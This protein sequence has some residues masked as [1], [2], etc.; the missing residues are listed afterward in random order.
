MKVWSHHYSLR[1]RV[2]AGLFMATVVYWSAVAVLTVKDNMSE[3]HELYDIHL[4]HTALAL[5]RVNDVG[6]DSS[7][8]ITGEVA[9][10]TIKQLFQKWPDLPQRVAP[11]A[12][13]LTDA[14]SGTPSDLGLTSQLVERNVDHGLTL[15]YQLWRNDGQLIFQSVN[16]PTTP[17][18]E[19]LGF[20]QHTDTSGKV[21]R[22]Y[23]IWDASHQLRAIVSE[24]NDDRMQLV[25]SIA[26]RSVNPI[27]LGMPIF[28]LLIWLSVRSGMG[29]LTDLGRAIAR[30]DASSLILIDSSKS[31]RELQPIVLALNSLIERMKQALEYERRFNANA[32]H[33][34]N[35]P[36]AAIKAHQ[37]IALHASNESE[38]R[39]ALEMAQAGTVR[40]IRLV[41]QMLAMARIDHRQSQAD[42]SSVNLCDLAQDVCAELSPLALRRHQTLEFVHAN[43]PML[44]TGNPDLLHR[45]VANLVDN[46]IRYTSEG[47]HIRV[48]VAC[49]PTDLRLTVQDD[50]PGIPAEHLDRIFDRYYRLADQSVHGTGLGLAICRTI[51]DIHQ[52]K[53]SL[54]QGTDGR[55][56]VVVISFKPSMDVK[57]SD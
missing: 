24:G 32:A 5:L 50:G 9:T 14:S 33:E 51:A 54:T 3:V 43:A 30:R 52:A 36:L 31:P 21:W 46:A 2:M 37:Y 45:L 16:S 25:R 29:P 49:T 44:M 22:D 1:Q 34:L 48:E 13:A 12:L 41:D 35:T 53:I 40:S 38:R 15:R 7:T 56:L 18:T 27:L 55:G 17:I 6:V 10:G 42:Q 8:A 28:I 19:A 47:G 20:S 4:A 57:A 11:G 23:S 26:I 39:H